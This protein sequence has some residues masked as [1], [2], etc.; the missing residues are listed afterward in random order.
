MN[1]VGALRILLLL[2]AVLA[3]IAVIR[4]LTRPI[5]P[6]E[7]SI[8][9]PPPAISSVERAGSMLSVHGHAYYEAGGIL[10]QG[11]SPADMQ[12]RPI[13][14][15][16][17]VL[18]HDFDP[19]AQS[20]RRRAVAKL[21][22][23]GGENLRIAW[24]QLL[25]CDRDLI[26]KV[27]T[28]LDDPDAVDRE[29]AVFNVLASLSAPGCV[30]KDAVFGGPV[31]DASGVSVKL[32]LTV[33]PA[34]PGQIAERL[35]PQKWDT[36]GAFFRNAYL[37]TGAGVSNLTCPISSTTPDPPDNDP[38]TPGSEYHAKLFEHFACAAC[39][40][41]FKNTLNIDAVLN[42]RCAGVNHCSSYGAT[43]RY[44]GCYN[45]ITPLAGCYGSVPAKLTNDQG[46][47]TVCN[48]SSG[49]GVPVVSRKE[50]KLDSFVGNNVL[51]ALLLI[52]KA[53]ETEMLAEIVCCD[54]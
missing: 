28:Q 16:V 1:L 7:C 3:A 10:P 33:G 38:R 5:V 12:L 43:E 23:Y 47:L 48:P 13:E 26:A 9:P 45:L 27:K 19:A 25:F 51:Y 35:D 21:A 30:P 8:P 20:R 50:I 2:T 15:A 53:E 42:K 46:D 22:A 39:G 31:L 17:S 6:R 4:W 14:S 44:Q 52:S 24:E 40:S 54:H 29:S 18:V 49:G 37:T 41:E 32:E 11:V 36:C 34:I